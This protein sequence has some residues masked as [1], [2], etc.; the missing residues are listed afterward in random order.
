MYQ[1]VMF[2]TRIAWLRREILNAQELS[3]R[4]L[5]LN[6]LQVEFEEA[7]ARIA[8]HAKHLSDMVNSFIPNRPPVALDVALMEGI[9]WK[10]KIVQ[11]H[12]SVLTQAFS[13]HV[14]ILN[15][16]V[17][18]RLQRALFW[19]TLIYTILTFMAV[20]ANWTQLHDFWDKV[21]VRVPPAAR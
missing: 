14:S 16:W 10:T 1:R 18:Y 13:E 9:D 20:I 4:S 8:H 6:R 2:G 21:H 7:K 5:L 3:R 12:V 19:L 17:M 15:T 11:R